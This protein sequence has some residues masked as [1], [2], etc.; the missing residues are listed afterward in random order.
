MEGP[1]KAQRPLDIGLLD[2]PEVLLTGILKH[3]PLKSKIQSEAVCRGFRKVLRK[4]SQGSFLWD[5][6][7]LND[8]VFKDT[9]PSGLAWQAHAPSATYCLSHAMSR[10]ADHII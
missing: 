7:E 4:P 8:L 2:L 9:D 5:A 6:I 10:T 3:L 1:R